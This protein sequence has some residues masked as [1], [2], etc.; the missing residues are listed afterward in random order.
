MFDVR[1]LKLM[2]SQTLPDIP[3]DELRKA[4]DL[5][6]THAR[7]S[8]LTDVEFIYSPSQIALAC[9][10]LASPQL[11]AAW[12]ASKHDINSPSPPSSPSAPVSTPDSEI[13]ALLEPIKAMILAEGSPP[14]VEAVREVDRRLKICKNPEK[15]VG[16]NAYKRKQEEQERKADEKRRRK[17][18]LVK[19]AMADG[20]PF[21]SELVKG[22][23]DDDD[24]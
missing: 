16:S 21:G 14:N 11:P 6:L 5:A 18:E 10:S 20:D 3:L 22:D 8:R 9:L 7:A 15:V 2:P 13:L 4:Y 23:L 12:L 17:A 19:K 24:D 1:L